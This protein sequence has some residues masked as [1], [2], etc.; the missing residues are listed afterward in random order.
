MNL[1]CK[2]AKLICPKTNLI[3]PEP[4]WFELGRILRT[5]PVAQYVKFNPCRVDLF[6]H[7]FSI[8]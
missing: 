7:K 5:K 2:T 6:K 8:K 3:Y 1:V 4:I